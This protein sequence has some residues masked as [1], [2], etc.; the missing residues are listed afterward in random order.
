MEDGKLLIDDPKTIKAWTFYDW[1]NSVFPLVITSAIFPNFYDYV[2]THEGTEFIGHN[3][4]FFGREFENQNIYTFIYAFA[5]S[6]VVL[7]SP[8]LSGVADYLGNKKRFLQFFCYLGSISCMCLFFFSRKNIELSFIPF[9]TATIGFWGSLVYYNSYLPEIASTENQDKVSAKGFAMGY[10][11]S[12][13]LLIICLIGIMVFKKNPVTGEGFFKVEYSFLLTGLWWLG[14]AQYT[15]KNLPNQNHSLHGKDKK[16]LVSKGFKELRSVAKQIKKLSQLKRFLTGYFFYNMG[17]QTVMVVAVLFARN[18]IIW[19]SEKAKTTSLIISILIIQFVGIAG[20]FIFSKL[21]SLLGNIKALMVAI[22]IWI[23]ICAFTYMYAYYPIH[24]YI[25]AFLVG[26]VMGGIQALSRS[27]YSK[28]LPETE[29][30]TSFFSFFDVMEKLGMILGT[31]TFGVISETIGGMRPS[32]L[33]L[34]VY[35]VLG[36][37]ILLTMKKVMPEKSAN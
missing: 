37:L 6:I 31:V 7:I 26:F 14:F 19:E 13:L 28:L 17:V 5:L 35:F 10:F 27:T 9:I 29:D 21:S 33:S 16:D 25:V 24:F 20:S 23:F 30:N 8:I 3:V 32:I 11:G 36:F 1:A 18:E 15:F 22:F 34:I 12:S 2:T 4:T